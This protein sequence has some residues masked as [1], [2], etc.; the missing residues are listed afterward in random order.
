KNKGVALIAVIVMIVLFSSLIM[1]IV[2]S[3]T[4][5]IKRAYYF[6][7]KL[8]ALEIAENAIQDVFNWMNYRFYTTEYYPSFYAN[9]NVPNGPTKVY[10]TGN[11]FTGGNPLSPP[12]VNAPYIPE[13]GEC[14]LEFLDDNGENKDTITAI[15]KYRGKTAKI[16]VNIRGLNGYDNDNHKNC[17]LRLCDR[18]QFQI[19]INFEPNGASPSIQYPDKGEVFGDRGNGYNYG[20]SEDRTSYAYD[21]DLV[22]TGISPK[23]DPNHQRFDTLIIMNGAT[24]EI[25]VPNWYYQVIIY[26]GDPLDPEC[27]DYNHDL[28]IEGQMSQVPIPNY[29]ISFPTLGETYRYKRHIRNVTVTDGRL[30]IQPAPGSEPRIC[31]LQINPLSVADWAIPEAFNKH[32]VY[33]GTISGSG[34]VLIDGNI[35]YQTWNANLNYDPK[36]RKTFTSTTNISIPQSQLSISIPQVTTLPEPTW[37]TTADLRFK[38]GDG[39]TPYNP[40]GTGYGTPPQ[41]RTI[42]GNTTDPYT[43]NGTNETYKFANPDLSSGNRFIFEKADNTQ[44]V[45]IKFTQNT[46]PNIPSGK[47]ILAGKEN[48]EENA[49]IIIDVNLGTNTQILGQLMAESD[50]EITGNIQSGNIGQQGQYILAAK[51]N[52]TISPNGN[53]TINGDIYS[54]NKLTIQANNNTI[55]INGNLNDKSNEILIQGTGTINI[56]GKIYAK[57]K[58]TIDGTNLNVT[59]NDEVNCE[60]QLEVKGSGNVVINKDVKAGL[61]TNGSVNL[62]INGS[63]FSSNSDISIGGTGNI[64]INGVIAGAKNITISNSNLEIDVSNTNYPGAICRDGNGQININ[65]PPKIYLGQNQ[66]S[67]IFVDSGTGNININAR[68]EPEYYKPTPQSTPDQMAIINK[69]TSQININNQ[70][71]GAIYSRGDITIGTNGK[72]KGTLITDREFTINGGETIYDSAPFKNNTEVYKGF[73]GG[74]RKYLPVIGSWR[75]EW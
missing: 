65:A 21:R 50:I 34:T 49:D 51:N 7:D 52:I 9:N 40:A 63:V 27:D 72:L 70:I 56:T 75:I 61:V 18:E 39:N 17:A 28:I 5:S 57:S 11:T 54:K 33:A 60:S 22:Y 59:I 45:Q 64:E 31:Y 55:T 46:E 67:A 13:K 69:T 16:I 74:R 25:E 14:I 38:D 10:F 20:W 26:C 37:P 35:T 44:Q 2:L 43:G 3:A 41:L 12:K 24:W 47:I 58:I 30:T 6:H 36:S 53:L 73:V 48:T 71:I 15:S 68:L 8:K 29:S 23:N 42:T 62:T 4:S 66:Y 19:N 32:L 1:V